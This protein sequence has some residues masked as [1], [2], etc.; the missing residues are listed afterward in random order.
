M[1]ENLQPFSFNFERNELAF[2]FPTSWKMFKDSNHDNSSVRP[3]RFVLKH[4][5][6]EKNIGV[7]NIYLYSRTSKENFESIASN[8]ETRFKSISGLE[9]EI[10]KKVTDNIL[11]PKLEKV[12]YIQGDL[13]YP[14]K[15]FRAV[16][17]SYLIQANSGICY[18]ESIGPRP[19]FKNYYWEASKR[20]IELMVES[21]D[22]MDFSKE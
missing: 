21:F 13:E 14:K 22:N 16:L 17:M 9:C 11:N 4:E 3:L 8:I 7:I 19:C 12:W 18:I 6:K 15:Q 20:C 10:Q 5:D 2:Y 1:A